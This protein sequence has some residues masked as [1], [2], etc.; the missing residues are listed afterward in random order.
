MKNTFCEGHYIW[1][2]FIGLTIMLYHI[3]LKMVCICFVSPGSQCISFVIEGRVSFNNW[4]LHG[5][6]DALNPY[7]KAISIIGKTLAPFDGDN[8]IPCFGFGDGTCSPLKLNIWRSFYYFLIWPL[9]LFSII[10]ITPDQEVFSFHGDHSPCHGLEA[11][12]SCYRK[13]ARNAKLAG[14]F[15]YP[16]FESW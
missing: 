12:L 1:Q 8:L 15:F 10:E 14:W 16:L 13:I 6:G 5:I 3:F 7:E 4:S 11:A 2:A 9:D